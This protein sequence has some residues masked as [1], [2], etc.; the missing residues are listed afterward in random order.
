MAL[1]LRDSVLT[2]TSERELTD[3]HGGKA[4]SAQQIFT[5]RLTDLVYSFGI[6]PTVP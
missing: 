1:S 6:T 4:R 2:R 3:K 5:Q